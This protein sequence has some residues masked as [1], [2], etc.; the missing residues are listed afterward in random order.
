[1]LLGKSKIKPL[2]SNKSPSELCSLFGDFFVEKISKIRNS[3]PAESNTDNPEVPE[4]SSTMA[5]FKSVTV[6]EVTK[7]VTSM[8]N[9]SC[10]LD[11]MPTSFVKVA[12]GALA[13]IITRIVNG[14]LMSGV[15]PSCYKEALVTPLLKKQSLDCNLLQNYRPVS[16]LTLI[17]K[18]IEKVVSAQLNTYLK[19]NNLL[20]PCQSAYRQGHSTETAL[21][22]VQNDVICAVGQQKAVL[23]VLLDLSAGIG[24]PS[25]HIGDHQVVATSSARNIGV[26]MDSKASMEAHVLSVCKSCFVHI[27]NL[28]RIKKFVNSSSLE[29]LVHAFI[30]TKLDYCNSLLCGAPST[31]I[32]KLQ[33]IQNIVARIIS[34]HGRCEHITPVLKSLHW[35][36]VQQRIK[37]KTLVLVYKA[38]NNMAPVYLQELLHPHVPCRGL[39]SSEKNLLV[40]PFTRSSAIQQCA[41]SA[42]GP[43][44]WNSLPLSL[45]SAPRLSVF[46]AQL[47]TYLFE[48]YYG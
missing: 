21:V 29:C 41:F 4:S 6:V 24:S 22:R 1:M 37:F 7:L 31:L 3:I 32:N 34:G 25:L 5:F 11:P 9:K 36:P 13:P 27:R 17:S 18:T 48:E 2:P 28:S 14:S 19:D 38:I 15:F 47:K 16:N 35:L 10:E 40:V 45:R 8:T 42:A 12:V 20:E 26:M 44:L 39:R 33:R 23:L 46:K 30:T 43:R